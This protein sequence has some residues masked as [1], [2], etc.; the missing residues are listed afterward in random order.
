MTKIVKDEI[1]CRHRGLQVDENPDIRHPVAVDVALG[2]HRIGP[3]QTHQ[4]QLPRRWPG[5][6]MRISGGHDPEALARLI[7]GC[8]FDPGSGQHAG[9]AGGRGDGYAQGVHGAG[10][11][12]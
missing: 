5:H 8:R 1:P 10:G 4:P 2:D 7:R 12:S 11:A 9:L 3:A 6:R